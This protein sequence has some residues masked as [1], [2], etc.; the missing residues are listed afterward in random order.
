MDAHSMGRIGYFADIPTT[1]KQSGSVI[2]TFC[3]PNQ[4]QDSSQPDRW[5]GKNLEVTIVPPSSG[6]KF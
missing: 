2:F 6:G 5:L 1:S 4:S 3:W